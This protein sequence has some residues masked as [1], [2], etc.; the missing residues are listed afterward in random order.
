M[1]TSTTACQQADPIYVIEL[2]N[3]IA[4]AWAGS[5]AIERPIDRKLLG[6]R[7]IWVP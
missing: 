1:R 2:A 6:K 5:T 4:M 3:V 7:T